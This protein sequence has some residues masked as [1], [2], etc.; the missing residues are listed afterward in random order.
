ML[1]PI[2]VG[3]I[4]TRHI[5]IIVYG[6]NSLQRRT[7]R[8]AHIKSTYRIIEKTMRIPIIHFR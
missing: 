1:I 6:V 3:I 7:K 2:A 5:G 8:T 4:P